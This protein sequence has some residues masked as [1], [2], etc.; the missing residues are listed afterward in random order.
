MIEDTPLLF[1]LGAGASQHIGYPLGGELRKQI[2]HIAN[3][4]R[5]TPEKEILLSM[6]HSLDECSA[7]YNA[8]YYSGQ[9]SIDAFLENRREF[10][11][12]GKRIMAQILIRYEDI[13]TLFRTEDNWYQYIFQK[14]MCPFE[15]FEYNSVCFITFN[16]DRSLEQYLFTAL[17]E[18]FNESDERVADAV[19]KIPIIHVHGK[20]GD[21]PW[22]T[23]AGRLYSNQALTRSISASARLLKIMHEDDVGDKDFLYAKKMLNKFT[24]IHFLGFGYHSLNLNRLGFP[25][26]ATPPYYNV[27]G[28]RVGLSELETR[29][30][31]NEWGIDTTDASSNWTVLQYLREM[32]EFG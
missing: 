1:I 29:T 15:E 2:L 17:K 5:S 3:S 26:I 8:F 27:F 21:L 6:G 31:Y 7:F 24:N 28:T 19:E 32:V 20:L 22:Q 14:M 9:N 10:I 4:D 23:P 25:E 11:S 16:Y 18:T 30:I 12:I 13:N